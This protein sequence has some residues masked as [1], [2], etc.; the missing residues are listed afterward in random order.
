VTAVMPTIGF[1]HLAEHLQYELIEQ[2]VWLVIALALFRHQPMAEV[3]STPDLAL[4]AHLMRMRQ[5]LQLS[6]V[7]KRQ[8][9]KCPVSSKPNLIATPLGT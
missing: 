6:I 3:L 1:D 5:L 9:R 8:G 4:P 2:V 7:E